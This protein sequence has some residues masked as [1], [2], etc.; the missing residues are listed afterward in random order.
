MTDMNKEASYSTK[1]EF[2]SGDDIPTIVAND[3]LSLAGSLQGRRRINRVHN[4]RRNTGKIIW[5]DV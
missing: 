5:N 1:P 3:S 2:T 4:Q